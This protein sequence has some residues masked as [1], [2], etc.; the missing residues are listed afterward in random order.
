MLQRVMSDLMGIR[1]VLVLNDEAHHCYRE[2]PGGAEESDLTS[3][4]RQEAEHN[5]EAARLWIKGLE[6]VQRKLGIQRVVDLSPPRSFSVAPA[7]G[8]A[9]SFP[10]P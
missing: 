4:E 9:R 10:G 7:T 8:R 3:E 5:R 6:T 1:N 2:K